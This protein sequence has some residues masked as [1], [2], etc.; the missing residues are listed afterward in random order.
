M[1]TGEKYHA[2][3]GEPVF[4]PLDDSTNLCGAFK[5]TKIVSIPW[6]VDFLS[7]KHPELRH[8]CG[9]RF[10][11]LTHPSATAYRA[12]VQPSGIWPRSVDQHFQC[13]LALRERLIDFGIDIISF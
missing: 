1:K 11:H 12:L 8:S 4:Q 9:L 2:Y 6:V 3:P 7:G 5:G 10:R 13:Y